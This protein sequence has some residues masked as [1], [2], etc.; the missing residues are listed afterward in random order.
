MAC[1][2]LAVNV[3][4]VLPDTKIPCIADSKCMRHLKITII[5]VLCVAAS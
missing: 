1:E 3:N 2:M 4:S 5:C